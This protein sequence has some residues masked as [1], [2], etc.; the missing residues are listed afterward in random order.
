MAIE[1]KYFLEKLKDIIEVEV[2]LKL[3]MK[4]S[5]LENIDSLTHMTISAWISDKY[6]K[7]ISVYEIEKIETIEELYNLIN[8]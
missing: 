4:F 6:E 7:K 1:K 3:D 2:E 5:E 8:S